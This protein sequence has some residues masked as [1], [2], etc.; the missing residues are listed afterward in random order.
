MGLPIREIRLIEALLRHPEGLTVA[1]LGERLGVSARTVHRDLPSASGFLGP[2]GL[3]LVR[4]AGRG[5][6]VEGTTGA[7]ERAL[8]DLRAMEPAL[9]TAEERKTFLLRTLLGTDEPV[10]LRA[11]ARRLKVSVGTVGRDLD[12]V[13]TWLSGSGLSLVRKR[14][15][16]VEVRGTEADLRRGIS[17]LILENLDE[18]TLLPRSEAPGVRPVGPPVD[19]VSER[20]MGMVDEVRL[21]AVEGLVG[22]AV[23]R[24]PHAI[25]DSAFVNLSV[26]VALMVERL[27]Q[28]RKVE[29]GDDILR[30][31]KNTV[32][33]G[34]ARGLGAAIEQGLGVGVPEGEVAYITMHL[35]GA[36]LSQDDALEGYF[37]TS[38]LELASRVKALIHYVG[39]QTGVVLVGDSSLYTGLLAHMERAVYRVRE[40]MRIYNP[41]LPEIKGDYP[42]L[43]DLVDRGVKRV[44]VDEEIPEEEIGFVA[45]HFGAALDRVQGDF[46]KRVL[47]ICSAGIGSARML[48]S[49]LETEFPQI[50]QI[51]NTSLFELPGID[52]DGFDLVV[53]TV[54]L[55]LPEDSYVQVRPLLS[56]SE[57]E[58]IRNHLRERSFRARLTERAASESLEVFG[59][60]QVKFSQMAEATEVIAGLMEDF[61]LV[62]HEAAGSV[63]E[64]ARLMCASLA[65]RGLVHDP[66]LLE[67]GLISRMGRGGIGIPQ[68]ALA[69]FHARD[70]TVVRPSFSA[71][72]LDEA[73]ELE[74]M[75]GARMLVRRGL[76][77]VAPL[78]ISPVALEAISEISVAMVERTADRETF[79]SG[80]EDRIVSVLNNIFARY[81]RYKLT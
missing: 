80:P 75:D 13:K 9:P 61:F 23:G 56:K 74:G 81:L 53:S 37:E 18:A 19:R 27:L 52:A 12:G 1:D 31:L 7:R 76:L 17:R 34:Y 45:M 29:M 26:H 54:S 21:R 78:E 57:V 15:Y 67:D 63:R 35:R 44:F 4:Q 47:V 65:E 59:G 32:E 14:G 50:R 69:L 10:K 62:R 5:L 71:H 73:L 8:E 48:A 42:A 51:R 28:G 2:R 43:F 11:L 55:P 70:A 77:M 6:R 33:Y 68:T 3:T 24:L 66:E 36:K 40:S 20:F 72:D 38:D 46:P 79:E 16:G 39:E 41:L 60:G 22:S 49:R 25:A 30:R 58:S 64:A